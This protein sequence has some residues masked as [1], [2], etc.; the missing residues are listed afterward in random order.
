[1][2]RASCVCDSLFPLLLCCSLCSDTFPS[3]S[4]KFPSFRARSEARDCDLPSG[5]VK[6]SP[7]PALT[8]RD[9]PIP[10]PSLYFVYT[11]PPF[12]S[13]GSP[14]NVQK[15]LPYPVSSSILDCSGRSIRAPVADVWSPCALEK[16]RKKK[17]GETQLNNSSK[18][19]NPFSTPP[20]TV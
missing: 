8:M 12:F 6:D 11:W 13:L 5:W 14:D 19:R 1:M 10:S 9:G 15:E 2:W 7:P 20:V 18:W 17:S 4:P 16:K 3:P